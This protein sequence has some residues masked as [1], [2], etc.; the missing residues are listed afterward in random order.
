M[1]AKSMLAFLELN[2]ASS[3]DNP[4]SPLF[5]DAKP[6]HQFRCFPYGLSSS[7]GLYIIL[8]IFAAP[9]LSQPAQGFRERRFSTPL[10]NESRRPP[11][12]SMKS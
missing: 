9:A 8:A 12:A 5:V 7:T 11:P 1:R 10:C 2:P 4:D 6:S 3:G